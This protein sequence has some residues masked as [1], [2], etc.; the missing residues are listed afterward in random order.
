MI[1]SAPTCLAAFFLAPILAGCHLDQIPIKGSGVAKTETRKLSHFEEVEV[2]NAI[3]LELTVGP[4]TSF[5][6]TTDDN[7]LPHVKTEVVGKQLRIF[8]DRSTT[9]NLGMKVKVTT[10]TL[11]ALDGSGATAITVTGA[12]AEKFSVD[13]SG[14]SKCELAVKADAL[15]LQL[16]GASNCKITGDVSWLKLEC[17]GASKAVT[18]QVA[19]KTVE[20]DL[21]GASS[22]EIRA[23]DELTV[24]A[25]GASSL[26][27][28]GS[29]ETVTKD[30]HGA[31]TVRAK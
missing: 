5:E 22:A 26:R 23:T 18:D 15:T 19:A 2:R 24:K 16:S 3:Q 30:V 6:I 25:S 29:P 20:A 1:R 10:P 9:T 17:S 21:S 8:T 14:A 27:Y 7:L 11:K 4:A 12:K 13:L 31:S 28:A